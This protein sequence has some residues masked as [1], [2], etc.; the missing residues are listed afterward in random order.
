MN[1]IL[2]FL[3]TS[4]GLQLEQGEVGAIPELLPEQA[5]EALLRPQVVRDRQQDMVRHDNNRAQMYGAQRSYAM[6][7]VSE[8]LEG[9]RSRWEAIERDRH[10]GALPLLRWRW[11]VFAITSGAR[12]VSLR[13]MSWAQW[14]RALQQLRLAAAVQAAEE[15]LKEEEARV[16][17]MDLP[18]LL[19]ELGPAHHR[20]HG[21]EAALLDHL[22]KELTREAR[23][24]RA[25]AVKEQLELAPLGWLHPRERSGA[26]THHHRGYLARVR[27]ELDRMMARAAQAEAEMLALAP[28]LRLLERASAA[29]G[30]SAPAAVVEQS[31]FQTVHEISEG[32]VPQCLICMC[33]C[34][35]PTVTRCLHIGERH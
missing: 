18:E 35:R 8:R 23:E 26:Q 19:E 14:T 29:G 13:S 2:R 9:V 1:E 28:Y 5:L 34:D 20:H 25:A 32:K 15:R 7:T 12:I 17:E 6:Q 16:A 30:A 10:L 24:V 22:R 3:V 27:E 31:G 4:R 11:A 33:P 21:P